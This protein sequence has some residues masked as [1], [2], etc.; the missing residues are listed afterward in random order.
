VLAA[1]RGKYAAARGKRAAARVTSASKLSNS[2]QH[3][4]CHTSCTRPASQCCSNQR[5]EMQ[6]SVRT[7]CVMPASTSCWACCTVNSQFRHTSCTCPAS[8]CCSRSNQWSSLVLYMLLQKLETDTHGV[9]G[10]CCSVSASQSRVAKYCCQC[11]NSSWQVAS[12]LGCTR[13]YSLL[14]L[15]LL[16]L[17]SCS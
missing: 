4:P 1:A 17:L 3:H 13:H 2:E 6:M 8:Q 12:S 5:Q 7:A 10:Y 16:L 14:V 15:L 9:A 11:Y